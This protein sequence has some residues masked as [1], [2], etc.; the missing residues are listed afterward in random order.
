MYHQLVYSLTQDDRIWDRRR[1]GRRS[2]LRSLPGL[3]FLLDSS[4][5]GARVAFLDRPA[6][7]ARVRVEDRFGRVKWVRGNLAGVILVG[8][9]KAEQR[10]RRARRFPALFPVRVKNGLRGYTIDLGMDGARLDLP[11]DTGKVVQLDLMGIDLWARVVQ[12]C[13]GGCRVRFVGRGPAQMK[14]LR[15]LLVRVS[16][17][18]P[19]PRSA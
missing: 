19:R 16:S 17:I 4:P 11:L 1:E 2:E 5:R 10:P 14:A 15:D 6:V 12:R 3:G 13:P 9:R 7:G 18:C 8:A